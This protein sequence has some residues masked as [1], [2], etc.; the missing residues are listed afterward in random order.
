MSPRASLRV[1]GSP[2]SLVWSSLER[3]SVCRKDPVSWHRQGQ[4]RR[5]RQGQGQRQHRGRHGHGH[6]ARPSVTVSVTD[7][8]AATTAAPLRA[9][10]SCAVLSDRLERFGDVFEA[11]SQGRVVVVKLP[12]RE[13]EALDAFDQLVGKLHAALVTSIVE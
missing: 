7:E 2:P 3:S 4:R 13:G 5:Q 1:E 10:V 9:S 8:A 12:D 6:R 11:F